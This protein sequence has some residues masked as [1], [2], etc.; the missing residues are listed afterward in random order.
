[1]KRLS[2]RITISVLLLGSISAY[3]IGREFGVFADLS[4]VVAGAL[5][6]WAV[7][8]W[9]QMAVIAQITF[10]AALALCLVVFA[11][12]GLTD[13]VLA[14]AM[15]RSAFF[16]FFLMS[17]DVLRT[18]AMS[19][20][21]VLQ[22]G[23][24][25]VSQPPGRRYTMITIGGHLFALL[26][27]LG[28][29]TLLGTM[30]RRS[31]TQGGSDT[32][33]NI[34]DI[35]LQRMT[36]ALIRGFT[37]FTMWAPTAVTAIVVVSVIPG[38]NWFQYAPIG[39]ALAVMYVITGWVFDRLSHPRRP[40]SAQAQPL[41]RVLLTLLPM[42]LL[43]V[44]ILSAAMLFSWL[45]GIRLIAALFMSVPAFGIAWI[46]L[47][48]RRNG[49]YRALLLT[50][51]RIVQRILPDLTTMRSEVAILSAAG[52]IAAVLPYQI[53]TDQLGQFISGLGLT[54]GW[55]L[56][57]LMWFVA[58]TSP[59]GLNP[60]IS[61]AVSVEIL[62]RLSGFHFNPY[63]LALGGTCAW[64]LATGLSPLGATIRI[65]GRTI[66]RNPVTIGL[67]WNRPFS[68]FFLLAASA[69]QIILN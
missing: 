56:V 55:L 21:M 29:I 68:I 44:S 12:G 4:P 46:F 3:A 49:S 33:P 63:L 13:E 6:I 66:N 11:T 39:F 43:T 1:M 48:Y 69:V 40:A 59:I 5:L 35:R 23:R 20:R 25:I 38:L 27:N 45:A 16:T 62:A 37:S 52:F 28:A 14:K 22:S 30:N 9:R 19:S 36:L 24:M 2:G 51:R 58:L 34:Q 57:L 41:S 50:R 15:G 31:I 60:I 32:D 7:L 53:D 18:A 61:V 8:E 54:E 65:S 42:S 10:A 47:Q 17:M 64:G 26:L 67:V